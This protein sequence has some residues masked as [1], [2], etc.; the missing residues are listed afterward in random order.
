MAKLPR[1]VSA[2][3]DTALK[4]LDWQRI[5]AALPDV[6]SDCPQHRRPVNAADPVCWSCPWWG[7]LYAHLSARRWR[8]PL[9]QG[10]ELK[11]LDARPCRTD[12]R[13]APHAGA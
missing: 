13:V 2:Y 4:G 10:R 12:G 7:V 8:S 6:C 5:D 11:F 1:D 9:M 3:L